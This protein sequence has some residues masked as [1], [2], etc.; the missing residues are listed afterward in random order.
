MQSAPMKMTLVVV[1][2]LIFLPSEFIN[3]TP[4]LRIGENGEEM[5]DVPSELCP[6]I[7]PGPGIPGPGMC[8]ETDENNMYW[9]VVLNN[10]FTRRENCCDGG[11]FPNGNILFCKNYSNCHPTQPAGLDD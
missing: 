1:C 9:C 8:Q 7:V 4:V 3:G 6:C 5:I 10:P 2:V 11:I